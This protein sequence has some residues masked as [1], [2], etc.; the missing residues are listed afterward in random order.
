MTFIDF[1]GQ[2]GFV[3]PKF[4]RLKPA[5]PKC[6]YI[7]GRIDWVT[8]TNVQLI[9]YSSSPIS[10]YELTILQS[11]TT[12]F[13]QMLSYWQLVSNDYILRLYEC[14]HGLLTVMS[15]Y[16]L[17]SKDGLQSSYIHVR[18]IG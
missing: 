5:Y 15:A 13:Q 8:F 14:K 18:K 7:T 4:E 16:M 12:Y 10:D 3:E 17:V 11:G 1:W 2:G 9:F 6:M